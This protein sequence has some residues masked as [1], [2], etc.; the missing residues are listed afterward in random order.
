[1]EVQKLHFNRKWS[2]FNEIA[3]WTL[4]SIN[5]PSKHKPVAFFSN[6]F[7]FMWLWF[8]LLT[9]KVTTPKPQFACTLI[10]YLMV[11]VENVFFFSVSFWENMSSY[12]ALQDLIPFVQFKKFQKRSWRKVNTPPWVFSRFL[13]YTNGT[14]LRS[15]SHM[16]N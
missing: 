10:F 2:V 15:A 14:K 7:I 3:L 1:M 8:I 13:N 11:Y 16:R 4:Q 12:D 9:S 6:I 5:R